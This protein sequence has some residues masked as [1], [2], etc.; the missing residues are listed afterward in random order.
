[1]RRKNL[2]VDEP[3]LATAGAPGRA[4]ATTPVVT[5]YHWHTIY[6]VRVTSRVAT[7]LCCLVTSGFAS[8]SELLRNLCQTRVSLWQV[9]SGVAT[10]LCSAVAT[11]PQIFQNP[12]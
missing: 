8:E 1:M 6:F 4:S 7:N 11:E 12:C 2:I 9:A 5:G 10:D 3:N